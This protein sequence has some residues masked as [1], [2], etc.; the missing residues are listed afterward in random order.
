M[1]LKYLVVL[2]AS[3]PFGIVSNLLPRK[4]PLPLHPF[5]A[6][7]SLLLFGQHTPTLRVHFPPNS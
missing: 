7:F 2:L 4:S 6:F 1:L 3:F 5:R